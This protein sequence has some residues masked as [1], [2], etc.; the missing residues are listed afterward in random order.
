MKMDQLPGA[1]SPF[2]L[3]AGEGERYAFGGHLATVIA[4]KQDMGIAMAGAVLTGA[5]GAS[6]PAHRHAASHEALYVVEGIV[7]LVLGQERYLLSPGD[8]VSVPA[9]TLHGYTWLD[10]RGKMISW[11]F[12]GDANT[13]YAAVG[14]PYSGT[15][16]PEQGKEVDWSQAGAEHDT[17]LVDAGVV[18]PAAYAKKAT[19]APQT[20]TP[21]VLG[22]AEGERMLAAEQ[23]YTILGNQHASNG[24]FLALMTEGPA[25]PRIPKHLHRHVS[26]TFFCL[27]GEM[28]MLVGDQ[29]LRLTPGDFLHIPPGTP[30]AFQ[31]LKNDTRFIGFLS[32]GDFENFFR[33]LCEPYQGYIYP[34]VPPPFRFDRVIPHLGELDLTVL[35]RPAGAPPQAGA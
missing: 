33:Y 6:F 30:H 8:Y 7:E 31:L 11:T 23:L 18:T 10:H 17:E 24:V 12:G 16:Y 13:V 25:G 3:Q 21:F 26:E 35:E 4:R 19:I 5:K 22:A 20:V 9:G 29:T 34:L 28:E 32:P 15:V 14:E 1:Q 27:H 2:M